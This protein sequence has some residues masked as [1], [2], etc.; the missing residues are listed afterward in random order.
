MFTRILHILNVSM[1]LLSHE[2]EEP[3]DP[4]TLLPQGFGSKPS[5]RQGRA[6][7]RN[8]SDIEFLSTFLQPPRVQTNLGDVEG[9]MLRVVSGR[10]VYAFEGIGY[11]EPPI[12]DNRFRVSY[13][14]V[15]HEYKLCSADLSLQQ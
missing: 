12:G 15:L 14:K 5:I 11:A 3:T 10:Y 4:T 13:R 1:N 8:D 2:R 9:F 7:F 6:K